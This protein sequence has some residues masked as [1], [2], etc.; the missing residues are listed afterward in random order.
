MQGLQMLAAE[1]WDAAHH[2][3]LGAWGPV[4]SMQLQ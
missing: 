4:T 2:G 1:A 3:R